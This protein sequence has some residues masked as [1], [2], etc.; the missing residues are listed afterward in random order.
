M[1]YEVIHTPKEMFEDAVEYLQRRSRNTRLGRMK[2]RQRLYREF[3]EFDER[4]SGKEG[5]PVDE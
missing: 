4:A 3:D 2:K 5:L 1:K